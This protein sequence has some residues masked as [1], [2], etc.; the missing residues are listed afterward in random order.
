MAIRIPWDDLRSEFRSHTEENLHQ[1]IPRTS[2]IYAHNLTF[3]LSR[4]E[5]GVQLS[6][7]LVP[8]FPDAPVRV[9]DVGAGNGG[10]SLALANDDRYRVIAVDI[11]VN[12]DFL[13]VR[14][15]TGL[16]VRQVVASGEHLPFPAN[17]FDAV[18]CL[19]T[20]EHVNAA[21]RLGEE[22]MRVLRSGG[23]CMITTPARLKFLLRPDPHFAVPRLVAWPDAIQRKI[24]VE[25]LELTDHYDVA[26]IYWTVGGVVRN[27]PGRT[28]VKTLCNIPYPGIPSTLKEWLWYAFR[29]LLWDRILVFKR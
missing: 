5:E 26:H 9:L 22:M 11:E 12:P 23:L 29:R 13:A 24:I 16:P 25:K 15:R 4:F 8:Y 21:R 14:R 19:E 3:A 27:L 17:L 7:F 10:V 20:I 2:P 18:L 1:S 28:R 6:S